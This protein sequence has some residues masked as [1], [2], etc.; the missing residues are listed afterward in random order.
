MNLQELQTV[1]QNQLP[2]KIMV[3]SN[4]GYL[5]IRSTQ[6]NFFGRLVGE[7]KASGISFP[8]MIRIADAY[9]IPSFNLSNADEMETVRSLLEQSGPL[10]VNVV[11]DPTQAFEPRL[12][13]K[14][15]ED[16]TIVTPSL[17]D[18]FP[19]LS[20]EE[21]ESNRYSAL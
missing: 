5:S 20:A 10:V 3:L 16:G 9:G 1:V 2:V 4:N 12:R 13:S 7:S 17:E 18:M 21:L 14:Q 6:S 11:L 15:L 19:F 8:D